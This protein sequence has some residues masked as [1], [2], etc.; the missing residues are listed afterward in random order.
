MVFIIYFLILGFNHAQKLF[1]VLQL[2]ITL[3]ATWGTIWDPRDPAALH[4]WH[5]PYPLYSL[6][7]SCGD[8]LNESSLYKE[9]Q[10]NITECKISRGT[11]DFHEVLREPGGALLLMFG[12]L[13]W[14]LNESTW[15]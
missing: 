7:S 14:Q 6:S 13:G 3:G 11:K 9:I 1:L 8:F 15:G 12:L 2:G 4:T 10:L 5:A